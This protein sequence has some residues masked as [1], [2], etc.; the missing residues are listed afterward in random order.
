MDAAQLYGTSPEKLHDLL[1]N[2]L[3]YKLFGLDGD[4]PYDLASF[5]AIVWAGERYNFAA[6]PATVR[7][8]PSSNPMVGR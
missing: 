3:G 8:N 1:S 2:E 4:G 7:A 5:A 6:R